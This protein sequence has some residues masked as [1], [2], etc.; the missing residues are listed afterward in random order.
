M[1]R[2]QAN[3]SYN[4]L[5]RGLI[6]EAGAL[7]FPE[8]ASYDEDNCERLLKGN[9]KRR[10]GINLEND[11]SL[12]SQSVSVANW[13]E[14]AINTSPWNTVGGSGN[15]NFTVVQIGPILYFYNQASVPFSD[16]Q[17]SFTVSLTDFA[18][19]GATN[20]GTEIVQTASGKGYLF[21]V[22][23]KIESFYIAYDVDTDTI[24]T[25]QIDIEIRD[26]EG[27]DDSLD[28]NEEPTTLSKEHDYN[29]KNQG[30]NSPATG[31]ANP[32]DTYFTSA[33]RYPAN[34]QQWW[35]AK[36]GSDDFSA[37]LMRKFGGGNTLAPRGHFILKA[38]YKD[39]TSASGVSNLS[40]ES[41]SGRPS[42]VGFFAGR[43]FYSGVSGSSINGHIFF[44]QIV[45]DT[46][47]IGRC[48][49]VNDP[50]SED[51]NSLLDTDG[52]VIV[53]PEAGSIL[54]LYPIKNS[55]LIFADNGI[56]SISGTDGGFKATDYR[57]SK[58][59]SIGI[60]G[61][62]SIVDADGTPVWW[63][64]TGIHTI[65][66]DDVSQEFG[67]T[68]I[69]H[70]TIQTFYNNIPSLSKVDAKGVYDKGSK[71]VRWLYRSTAQS[72]GSNRYRFDSILTLDTL[73]GGF[74]PWT[75]SA[76][77]SNPYYI[78][79]AFP[80]A[81]VSSLLDDFT[82]VDG[83]DSVVDGADTI[84]AGQSINIG[85][86]VF[87][88]YLVFRETSTTVQWTFGNFTSTRFKDWLSADNVGVDYDSF[89]ETGDEILEDIQR[90]KQAKYL[91][92]FFNRTE[93]AY[94][95]ETYTEWANPSGCFVQSRW[96]WS[97]H[98]NSHKWSPLYQVYR[99]RRQYT[100][101]SGTDFDSGFPVIITKNKLRGMGRALRLRFSSE[102]GKDFDVL[103]WAI[104]YT[105]NTED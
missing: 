43:V 59:S 5:Q 66:V 18:A 63:A 14:Y 48:Y 28:P 7:N 34:S 29:L 61:P 79:S 102:S 103:G 70:Q 101:S 45:E 87:V 58:V 11:F 1:P 22:G 16:G 42:A 12:S 44:S 91:H 77:S 50:T 3:K 83:T 98:I 93:T 40:V 65:Q 8:N 82:V 38:F 6:T 47:K 31:I 53:I 88:N 73:L 104:S 10:L 62:L 19:P 36:D 99:F 32:K 76:L 13:A 52:G 55:L 74:Y 33:G 39:R 57:V 68:N 86:D 60:T 23:K 94:T 4:T 67:V 15:L 84:V 25:T 54:A 24:T 80:T 9:I 35:Q 75:I 96:E 26:F 71:K 69:S 20:I 2:A 81:S 85:S 41:V 56:W 30:W 89:F 21:V 72:G 95:D 78:G 37:A 27:L 100:P 17:K 92:V 51:L 97:D 64:I 90:L 105:G 46:T 49:Q